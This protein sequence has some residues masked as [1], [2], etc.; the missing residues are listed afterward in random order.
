MCTE[1][2]ARA[3]KQHVYVCD[4]VRIMGQNGPSY[5]RGERGKTRTHT[6]RYVLFLLFLGQTLRTWKASFLNTYVSDGGLANQA[7]PFKC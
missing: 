3:L 7:D 6:H 2:F 4:R 5:T 1:D